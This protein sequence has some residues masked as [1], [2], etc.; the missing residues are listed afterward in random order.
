MTTSINEL[1]CDPVDAF[2][3]ESL[4]FKAMLKS[5]P[6]LLWCKKYQ[7]DMNEPGILVLASENFADLLGRK[8][9]IGK[10]DF[11]LFGENNARQIFKNDRLAVR[12][13]KPIEFI[14]TCEKGTV[15]FFRSFKFVVPL[16]VFD[17]ID[18]VLV[19][20]VGYDIQA[21]FP[22]TLSLSKRLSH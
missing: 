9:Y 7:K 20:G 18:S 14:E 21:T 10:T 1:R 11:E 4:L 3:E 5:S 6:V 15:R 13:N 8:D 2:M 16:D 19:G 12:L 17:Y 22:Q